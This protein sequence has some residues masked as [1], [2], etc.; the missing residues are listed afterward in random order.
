MRVLLVIYGSLDQ[1]SGG[2]L[3]DRLV[4]DHLRRQGVEVD[5]LELAPRPYLLAWTAG[6]GRR[7]RSLLAGRGGHEV[8][9]VD[10]L[11]HPS[12][13][14]AA[15][16]R[17]PGAPPLVILVHH[18]LS[19]EEP[20][21]P[22]SLLAAALERRLL[23]E[24]DLL[25]VNSRTTE[26]TVR[27]L[28]PRSPR[29]VV[30]PP[31]CDY[32]LAGPSRAGGKGEAEPAGPGRERTAAAPA[33]TAGRS[34]PAP[35]RLLV[36]GNVIPRKGYDLLLPVLAGLADLSWH[37]RVVGNI[38]DRRYLRRLQRLIRRHGLQRRVAF[39]GGLGPEEL[40]LEYRQADL[41]VFTSRYEGYGISVAEAMRA[42]LPVAAFRS[43]AVA[44]VV[45]SEAML[46]PA[47][48]L[49]A[50]GRR[51]RTLIADP[52]ERARLSAAAGRRAER[53]PT[54]EQTGACFLAA[55]R[56]A[57]VG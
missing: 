19:S 3:Y 56:E 13:A 48:D 57:S 52:R 24:S 20:S 46:V 41:F 49:E 6:L 8:V 25:I 28:A 17:P 26:R 4:V 15:A 54:W 11:V 1:L 21:F 2:Y 23:E 29:A 39:A 10:E 53:L 38:V 51:L 34:D 36:T 47:G 45:G 30:C 40:R 18:L 5:T 33:E 42:G 22:L 12:V 37:L 27:R 50:L 55:L 14:R 9:V 31:G 7:E 44:E 43:G 16:G 35:V 32:V